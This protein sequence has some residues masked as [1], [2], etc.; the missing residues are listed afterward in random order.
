MTID[1]VIVQ[2]VG[3]M[4]RITDMPSIADR[5]PC[6]RGAKCSWPACDQSCDGRPGRA[7]PAR[8]TS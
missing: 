3:P 7:A 1:E 5:I 6:H 8:S 4:G 2:L